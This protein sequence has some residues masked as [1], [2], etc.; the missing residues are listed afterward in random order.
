MCS[1]SNVTGVSG[2]VCLTTTGTLMYTTNVGILLLVVVGMPI[3]VLFVPE[4]VFCLF[5]RGFHG[6]L[7][8]NAFLMPM[9][10]NVQYCFFSIASKISLTNLC[11]C[12]IMECLF[13]NPNW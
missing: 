9:K 1:C 13:L 2:L 5:V 12:S 10:K 11:I 8:K 4:S 3:V 7:Y 6:S